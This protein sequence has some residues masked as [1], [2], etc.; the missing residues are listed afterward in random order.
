[1]FTLSICWVWHMAPDIASFN[2]CWFKV[3]RLIPDAKGT[4]CNQRLERISGTEHT[5]ILRVPFRTEN[6]ILRKWISRFDVW[7]YLETFAEVNI[8]RVLSCFPFA[9]CISPKLT[10]THIHSSI[11][12]YF[13]L[14]SGCIKWNCCRV[15]GCTRSDNWQLQRWKSCCISVII[16]TRNHTGSLWFF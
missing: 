11:R 8:S 15:T 10:C 9:S 5:H 6:G 2:A 13:W 3:T 12:G 14:L 7:P 1:M 4:T 16:Q